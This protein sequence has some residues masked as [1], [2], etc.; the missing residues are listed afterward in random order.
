MAQE[1]FFVFQA[2][3]ENEGTQAGPRRDVVQFI[4]RPIPIDQRHST[5]YKS[6]LKASRDPIAGEGLIIFCFLWMESYGTDCFAGS[7]GVE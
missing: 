2:E 5:C 1:Y 4:F 6:T 3:D 7:C